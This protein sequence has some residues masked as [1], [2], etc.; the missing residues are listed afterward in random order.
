GRLAGDA[1]GS[2]VDALVRRGAHLYERKSLPR[3]RASAERALALD[4]SNARARALLAAIRKAELED[5]FESVDGVVGI[6]RVT[7][8]RLAAG[9]PLRDRGV[10][11]RR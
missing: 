4:P 11:R 3:A 9:V 1:R 2:L 8:R 7:A 6:D 10:A 5:I